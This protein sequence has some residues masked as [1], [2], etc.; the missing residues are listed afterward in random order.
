MPQLY[1]QQM[2]DYDNRT[3]TLI[4]LMKTTD[5]KA[6]RE[7]VFEQILKDEKPSSSIHERRVPLVDFLL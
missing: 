5:N 7:I 1:K 3:E 4:Y 2:S 6:E